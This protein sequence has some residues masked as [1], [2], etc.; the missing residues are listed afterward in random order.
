MKS[1]IK[2]FFA[3]VFLSSEL[4]FAKQ[5]SS[6]TKQLEKFL[7]MP[8]SKMILDK[9]HFEKLSN[10]DKNE[11]FNSL[12]YL[13][14]VL[15]S[16]QNQRFQYEDSTTTNSSPKQEKD[17]G[18]FLK[19]D[20]KSILNAYYNQFFVPEAHAIFRLLWRG[21]VW[22]GDRFAVGAYRSGQVSSGVR[23]AVGQTISNVTKSAGGAL[24][25]KTT[26]VL[27]ERMAK[28]SSDPAK[29]AKLEAEIAQKYPKLD[30]TKM[31]ALSTQLG[32]KD[33]LLADIKSGL[34]EA[35]KLE[36]DLAK[37]QKIGNKKEAAR[38]TRELKKVR[39]Q[40][41]ASDLKYRQFGDASTLNKIYKNSQTSLGM[42]I[43]S[44]IGHVGTFGFL[45]YDIAD[46]FGLWGS[47]SLDDVKKYATSMGSGNDPNTNPGQI[48]KEA[49]FSCLYGG[50]P[51]RFA[52]FDGV[53]KCAFPQEASTEAC[54]RSE[55]K[56]LCPDYG[57]TTEAYKP[58]DKDGFCIPL[59]PV[60]HLT[61]RCALSLQEAV[62]Q[63]QKKLN[64]NQEA[65]D[66]YSKHVGQI[67]T[68]LENNGMSD[69]EDKFHTFS[70][71]CEKGGN[72]Q[73]EECAALG[74]F[75]KVS[76]EN[77]GISKQIENQIADN[78]TTSNEGTD[79]TDPTKQPDATK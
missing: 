30:L 20:K 15:E 76:A 4:T 53:P 2:I 46:H 51:S 61:K 24:S 14:I 32:S 65:L 66:A 19:E 16:F 27:A 13:A 63:N 5:T 39:N 45:G 55:G 25:E 38:L 9:E 47:K 59:E 58:L 69:K 43:L 73:S 17:T 56:F 50:R 74:N 26:R 57:F 21:L 31:R 44:T 28:V 72:G 8:L 54:N 10:E 41:S 60:K 70:Y 78:R 7:T 49:G 3:F 37:A 68:N 67:I 29:L 75:I 40:V 34:A 79:E 71:Y 6:N 62:E 33:A 23:T 18:M 52:N 11:Y 64:G 12:V 36:S 22:A 42:R 77:V 48:K 35:K 1:F